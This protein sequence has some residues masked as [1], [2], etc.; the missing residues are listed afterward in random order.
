MDERA[1]DRAPEGAPRRTPLG[2]AEA[3]RGIVEA[4]VHLGIV[5]RHRADIAGGDHRDPLLCSAQ[6]VLFAATRG[7]RQTLN[8]AIRRGDEGMPE[9]QRARP[10]PTPETMHFWEGTRAGELRL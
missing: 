5:G 7:T 9:G 1:V 10:T 4:P 2:I 6:Q 3:P 8:R